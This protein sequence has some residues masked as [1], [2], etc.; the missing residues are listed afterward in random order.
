MFKLPSAAADLLILSLLAWWIRRTGGRSFQLAIYAWNPLVIVEFAASG[1]NDSLAILA[2][3]AA[4]FVMS[5][6]RWAVST[7]LLAAGALVKFFPAAL[8]PLWLRRMQWPGS[9]RAWRAVLAGAAVAVVCAWPYRAAWPAVL[10]HLAYFA[11][12]WHHNNASL[13]ALLSWLAGPAALQDPQVAIPPGTAFHD[14]AAGLG[15]GVVA[16]IALWAAARQLDP[17]RAAYLIF[18]AALLLAPNAFPWYFTWM[19]PLLV[20]FPHP[21]WLLLTVLQFLSYHVLIDYQAFGIWRFQP[22]ML[23][24]TYGPFYAWLAVALLR[25]TEGAGFQR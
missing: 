4:V 21:A 18:G 19:V 10:G 24:L 25:R 11:S 2:V 1:H 9:W 6:G 7:A 3:L 23:W 15:L 16:G 17:L 20:F 13:Y 12:R 22:Q 8:F 5:R 14:F